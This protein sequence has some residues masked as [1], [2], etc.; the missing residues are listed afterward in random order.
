M[1]SY[2]SIYMITYLIQS[3]F[4]HHQWA[5]FCYILCVFYPELCHY[6]IDSIHHLFHIYHLISHKNSQFHHILTWQHLIIE[7]KSVLINNILKS[8]CYIS[9]IQ[10]QWFHISHS[11]YGLIFWSFEKCSSL[12]IKKTALYFIFPI[13]WGGDFLWFNN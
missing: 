6:M 7:K 12:F 10:W 5:N 8:N 1:E 11:P 2:V 4:Y 3:N 9:Y 13:V